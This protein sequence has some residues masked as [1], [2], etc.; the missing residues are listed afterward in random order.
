MRDSTIGE[1]TNTMDICYLLINRTS[2]SIR[3][4]NVI[5]SVLNIEDVKKTVETIGYT[6]AFYLK[7][8]VLS[9]DLPLNCIYDVALLQVFPRPTVLSINSFIFCELKPKLIMATLTSFHGRKMY[10]G[11][12]DVASTDS[13]GPR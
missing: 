1:W 7:G 8:L 13:N 12:I 10:F 9:S 5:M 11:R 3:N 6:S 2:E 4:L